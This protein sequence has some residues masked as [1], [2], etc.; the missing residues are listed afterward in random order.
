MSKLR[1]ELKAAEA[2][3]EGPSI[4]SA[5]EGQTLDDQKRAW[6]ALSQMAKAQARER[7]AAKAAKAR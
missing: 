2:A 7:E 5:L 3:A 1:D 6:R 4:A